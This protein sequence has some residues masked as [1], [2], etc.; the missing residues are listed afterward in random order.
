MQKCGVKL[1]KLKRMIA[2]VVTVIMMTSYNQLMVNAE[3]EIIEFEANVSIGGKMVVTYLSPVDNSVIVDTVTNTSDSDISKTYNIN[4]NTRIVV[5]YEALTGYR[6]DPETSDM[7]G[8]ES[9]QLGTYEKEKVILATKITG[10]FEEQILIEVNYET[11]Y[12]NYTN[13]NRVSSTTVKSGEEIIL[14]AE[15]LSGMR[16]L[17]WYVD[18]IKVTDL[19]T[20]TTSALVDR[21]YVA[22]YTAIEHRIYVNYE[23]YLGSVSYPNSVVHG[24]TASLLAYPKK[25]GVFVGWYER[26]ELV[27]E[28]SNFYPEITTYHDY[29][30]HF[31]WD[32]HLVQVA[33]V[34]GGRTSFST[35]DQ[36][37]LQSGMVEHG[38]LITLR[39]ETD[40]RYY[41]Q[42]WYV[43]DEYIGGNEEQEI[44]VEEDL[45]YTARFT[46]K[47]Y[48]V[49][50]MQDIGGFAEI[51]D[52]GMSY[53][54]PY[55]EE[56]VFIAT[57]E[58][59]YRFLYWKK[60]RTN[61][62][63]FDQ[64]FMSSPY[65]RNYI[66]EPVF[67]KLTMVEINVEIEGEGIAT[68][69]GQSTIQV[70]QYSDLTFEVEPA[71]G[72]T[73]QKWNPSLMS[74]A[75]EDRTYV[76]TF[77]KSVEISAESDDE[78]KGSA[79]VNGLNSVTVAMDTQV[80]LVA[81]PEDNFKFVAWYVDE[82]SVSTE[83]NLT[84]DAS[85]NTDYLAIFAPVT[86]PINPPG[87]EKPVDPP[88]DET[89]VT[90]SVI[91][92]LT[93]NIDGEGSVPGFEEEHTFK[94]GTIVE[95][96]PRAS[97]GSKFVGWTGET[98]NMN[99]DTIVMTQNLTVTAVFEKIPEVIDVV[100]L[101]KII[102][103]DQEIPEGV[104]VVEIIEPHQEILDELVAEAGTEM[105]VILDEMLDEAIDVMILED[106]VLPQASGVPFEA[107]FSLGTM[108]IGL[109]I[110]TKRKKI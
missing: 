36:T 33:K 74:I 86:P 62:I 64:P 85:E 75:Y 70:Y 48:S 13:N 89:P 5:V 49:R 1:M 15:V 28:N 83:A 102:E 60:Y 19:V 41:F 25:H 68:V 98:Q 67:E 72:Y 6:F 16:F 27:S 63:I 88:K 90:N 71:P 109:G 22:R 56:L 34:D 92:T 78:E 110:W 18:N 21:T 103:S 97:A 45:V 31:K 42:G 53:R 59:G 82:V 58:E 7:P 73:F 51:Q 65:E 47:E 54:G 38:E 12:P 4:A 52:Y 11:K 37:N 77:V 81:I 76:A 94:Q 93:V 91:Y 55:N 24:T 14:V 30:A 106:Q 95:L 99:D 17:G 104:D 57:P 44:W 101:I 66:F 96:D 100:D 32:S 79:K 87:D 8:N 3:V 35:N 61:S 23:N 105:S 20:Y 9:A 84:V 69:N 46:D 107:I 26:G 2:L 50:L 10:N 43:E 40:P 80:D 29:V 108:L 39:V